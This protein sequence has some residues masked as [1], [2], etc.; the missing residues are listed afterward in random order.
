M[1]T[2]NV[3]PTPQVRSLILVN[4]GALVDLHSYFSYL[5]P[6][7]LIHVIDSH[8]PINLAN[9]YTPSSYASALLD[10]TRSRRRKHQAHHDDNLPPPEL[11]VIIWEDLDEESVDFDHAGLAKEAW[12]AMQYE[13]E[14]D[15]DEDSSDD[16]DDEDVLP[17]RRRRGSGGDDEEDDEDD[18]VEFDENGEVVN[19]K[20][21]KS[22][23][24]RCVAMK[25]SSCLLTVS[26]N[27]VP[28]T[29]VKTRSVQ[30]QDE[31]SKVLL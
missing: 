25:D 9:L 2:L 7:C 24:S 12:E 8:R 17:R 1:L 27:Q 26:L 20:R 21:K 31:D 3:S 16:E 10:P 14:S 18:D 5:P 28:S 23:V 6:T 15:S 30:V 4:L 19:R 11:S 29:I 13:P 22:G